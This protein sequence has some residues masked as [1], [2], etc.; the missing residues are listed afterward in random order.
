[1]VYIIYMVYVIY[2][3]Y[4]V[5]FHATS[6]SCLNT[7]MISLLYI[8]YILIGLGHQYGGTG[9]GYQHFSVQLIDQV[10]KGDKVAL[11][12]KKGG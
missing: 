9:C 3:I 2:T 10:E 5:S 6:Y 8:I 7:N 4:Y 11:A 12:E 1:M